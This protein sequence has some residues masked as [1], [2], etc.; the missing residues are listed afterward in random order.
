M[1]SSRPRWCPAAGRRRLVTAAAVEGMRP[2]R[3]IVDLAGEA[4]G[5]C[6]LT[7]P[8]QT[9]VRHDVTIARR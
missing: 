4:G 9:V 5:N 1:S 7:E 3:V 6:E 2:G 8:G